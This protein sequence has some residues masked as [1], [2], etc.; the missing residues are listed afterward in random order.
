MI[1]HF[2]L[3]FYQSNF[4]SQQRL[5]LIATQS[6]CLDAGCI[7]FPRLIAYPPARVEPL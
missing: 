4:R 6:E 3:I 5:G 1:R 7:T 2:H